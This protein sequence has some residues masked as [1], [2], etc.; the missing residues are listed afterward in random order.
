M[1]AFAIMLIIVEVLPAGYGM[2]IAWAGLVM[3][4]PLVSWIVN[5][6]RE[7]GKHDIW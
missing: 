2:Y 4:Y 6:I 1:M 7:E 3:V 5:F